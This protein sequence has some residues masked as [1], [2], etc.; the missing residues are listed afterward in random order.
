MKSNQDPAILLLA[1]G[2]VFRGVRCGAKGLSGGEIAFNTAMTGYQEVF[3]DPSYHGQLVVMASVHIGNYGTLD[4]ESESSSNKVS[5]IVVSK[6]SETASRDGEV[7]TLQAFMERDGI[8]G[9][10]DIDT[11]RLVRHI[12]DNGAMNAIISSTELDI[13][14][15]KQKLFE[16]P[17]MSGRELSSAIT[18]KETYDIGNTGN[19]DFVALIDFGV[20]ENIVRCLVERGFAV[21]VYPMNV[22]ADVVINDRPMGILFSNGPGDPSAM[23]ESIDLIG[24][25]MR[26]GIPCFGICLG[27]QLLGLAAGLNTEKMHHGHRGINHPV[28]NTITGKCEVTSQNHGFVISDDNAL[29]SSEMIVTHRHLNDNTIAG[30]RHKTLPVFSVQFHPEAAAGPHDSRYLFDEFAS[31]MR[32]YAQSIQLL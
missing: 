9:I 7:Q 20:K 24:H 17:D 25:L 28:I 4:A 30:I 27:H 15:L 13:N 5:G 18:A 31:D 23:K 1:D 2:T 19:N 10:T 3:T 29:A 12:R 26:E 8:V 14:E 16:L 22:S 6:F 32:A 21:R 11:R